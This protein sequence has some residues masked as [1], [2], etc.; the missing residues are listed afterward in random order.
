MCYSVS[1]L[2]PKEVIRARFHVSIPEAEEYPRYYYVSAFD[3]PQLPVICGATPQVLS[4]YR[5]GL[6]PSWVKSEQDAEEM[7]KKTMNARAESIFEKPAFRQA[8]ASQHCLVLVDGFF[9]WQDVNGRKY[10]YFL[11]LKSREPFALAGLWELWIHPKTKQSLH[12]VSIVTCEASPLLAEIHNSAKRMPVILPQSV[13]RQWIAPGLA[14]R[15]Y[16]QLLSAFSDE[17]LEAFTVA[18]LDPSRRD[19]NSPEAV[20]PFRYPELTG[21]SSGQARLF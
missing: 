3:Y 4:L 2:S 7:R 6:I 12:T 20:E 21:S 16:Q 11:R 19:V 1:V 10:P 9:E 15:Q 14:V 18:K 8:A 17:L 13:E 5:W